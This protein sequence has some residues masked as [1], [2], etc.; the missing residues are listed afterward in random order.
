MGDIEPPLPRKLPGRPKR[1]ESRGGAM[2][3]TKGKLLN[4][5]PKLIF[6]LSLRTTA[7]TPPTPLFPT[8]EPPTP[9]SSTEPTIP[10]T[11]TSVVTPH[12]STAHVPW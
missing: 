5:Y 11:P 1:K 10:P 6:I 12:T 7:P 4:Q 3:V 9:H 2:R 8:E